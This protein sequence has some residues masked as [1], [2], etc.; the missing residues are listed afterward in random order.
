G[1]GDFVVRG[2]G[3]LALTRARRRVSGRLA[4][5][6]VVRGGDAAVHYAGGVLALRPVRGGGADHLPLRIEALLLDGGAAVIDLGGDLHARRAGADDAL[7]DVLDA[8]L[9][10]GLGLAPGLLGGG[11]GE[12]RV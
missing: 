4:A 2:L 3:G 1:V 10:L 7:D 8:S 12:A 11:G 5:G 9:K 6:D